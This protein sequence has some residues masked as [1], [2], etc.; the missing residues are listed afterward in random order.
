LADIR[1]RPTQTTRTTDNNKD[2]VIE[3]HI[4]VPS[5]LC[6]LYRVDIIEFKYEVFF[7]IESILMFT[8]L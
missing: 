1:D 5:Y 8:I 6:G 3:K 2:K 7:K 4:Y